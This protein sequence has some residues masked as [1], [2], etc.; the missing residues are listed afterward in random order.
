MNNAVRFIKRLL[1]KY[2]V[3][4][5]YWV[6]LKDIKVPHYF[7]LTRI[8]LKKWNHKMGYWLRTG[9]FESKILLH[10]D[11]TLADGFS[12]VKIAYLKKLER[13]P[14]YFID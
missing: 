8:G 14:V 7:K 3:G 5:E 4:Y 12:S 10:R 1:G 2:E 6:D 13:V 11:F 9:E